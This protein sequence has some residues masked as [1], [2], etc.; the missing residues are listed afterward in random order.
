MHGKSCHDST[1]N[2][3]QMSQAYLGAGPVSSCDGLLVTQRLL[4]GCSLI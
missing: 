3:L 4:R 2:T 1:F